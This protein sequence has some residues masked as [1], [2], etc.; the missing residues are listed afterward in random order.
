[1]AI[2]MLSYEVLSDWLNRGDGEARCVSLL[3]R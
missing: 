1:M 3:K 2:M